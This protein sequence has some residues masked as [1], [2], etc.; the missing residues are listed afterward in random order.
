MK[1]FIWEELP[2]KVSMGKSCTRF[3]LRIRGNIEFIVFEHNDHTWSVQQRFYLCSSQYAD[4]RSVDTV[5]SMNRFSD[6]KYAMTACEQWIASLVP[7]IGDVTYQT[8]REV[9]FRN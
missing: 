5:V 2:P 4:G 3:V 6:F 9:W 1:K 8:T 7:Q